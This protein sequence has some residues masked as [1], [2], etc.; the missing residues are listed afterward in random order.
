MKGQQVIEN[1]IK[2]VYEGECFIFELKDNILNKFVKWY[3]KKGTNFIEQKII[4]II[5]KRMKSITQQI[6]TGDNFVNDRNKIVQSIIED[7][8]EKFNEIK[9]KREV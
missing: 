6:I 4:F 9:N 1:K 8:Q 3:E 5:Q 7:I 2:Y